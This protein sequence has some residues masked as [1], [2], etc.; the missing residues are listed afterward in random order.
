MVVFFYSSC[1]KCVTCTSKRLGVVV[2][3]PQD[4][5]GKK[6]F[7]DIWS[8]AYIKQAKANG[9]SAECINK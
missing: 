5:C 9:Y 1:K 2:G 7:N 4:Y 3:T 6:R 8:A